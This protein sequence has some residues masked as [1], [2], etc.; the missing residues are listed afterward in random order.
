[1]SPSWKKNAE[2]AVGNVVGSNI[3][4]VFF[5][6]G[7]SSLI[8]PLPLGESTNT[9]LVVMIVASLVLFATMFSGQRPTLERWEGVSMIVVYAVY[10]GFVFLRR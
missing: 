1:M 10:C 2:I 4:N 5:I 7:A 8:H 3:V 9:D 6:L